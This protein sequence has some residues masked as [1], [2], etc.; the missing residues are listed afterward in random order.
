MSLPIETTI[1]KPRSWFFLL[2][3]GCLG[4]VFHFASKSDDFEESKLFILIPGFVIL[5]LWLLF[6]KVSIT[7]DNDGLTYTTLFST[8][9]FLWKDVTSTWL[10]FSNHG[11][12]GQTFWYFEKF[13]KTQNM[14]IS[15]YPRKSLRIIAETVVTKCRKASIDPKITAMAEGKFPWYI[16]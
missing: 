5:L 8:Q 16:F 4:I 7:V 2:M 15:F 6:Q 9:S 14:D 3:L 12:S 1:I 13:D 11:K 10:K